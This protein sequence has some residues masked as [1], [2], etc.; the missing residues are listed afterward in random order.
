ML[1]WMSAARLRTLPLALSSIFMGTFLAIKASKFDLWIFLFASM[2]TILLQILSNFA[3]DYGDFQNGADLTDRIGPKRA[4]QSGEISSNQMKIAII[5]VAFLAFFS[6]L[7]L[8][9]ISFGGFF[10]TL[11]WKFIALGILCIIAAYTYTAGKKPYGYIGFGDVSVFIFFGIVGVMGSSFVFTKI[12]DLN[13]I[14]P[15]MFCGLL[16]TGVLNLNN[17]RDIESDKAAGKIT[18]PVRLGRRKAI[19]YHFFLLIL[20][21]LSLFSFV[22]YNRVD[23]YYYLISIPLILLNAFQ[24]L[25]I[26]NPDPLLK[27][28]ALT[29]LISVILFGISII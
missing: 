4:V 20:A 5:I 15:A 2:T 19:I 26:K 25:K 13:T 7:I 28:L 11:F 14:L 22:Y 17:I 9:Y 12:I 29:I 23:K 6:G 8:L 24:L 10:S 1:K 21:I 3:N 16:S 18:I 27:R